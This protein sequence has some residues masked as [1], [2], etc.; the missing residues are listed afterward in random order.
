MLRRSTLFALIAAVAG[1]A[2]AW[3]FGPPAVGKMT[4]GHELALWFGTDGP[5]MEILGDLDD[6]GIEPE[7]PEPRPAA[8][9][10]A[11]AATPGT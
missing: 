1:S 8:G 9:A 7:L 2:G 5:G 3:M 6:A 4:V 10:I 11:S